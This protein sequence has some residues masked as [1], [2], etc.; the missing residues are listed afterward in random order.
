VCYAHAVSKK[1]A[2]TLDEGFDTSEF[3]NDFAAFMRLVAAIVAN[4]LSRLHR[5][6]WRVGDLLDFVEEHG[7]DL[8]PAAPGRELDLSTL[9][10]KL[11]AIFDAMLDERYAADISQRQK[12][13]ADRFFVLR[14]AL[15]EEGDISANENTPDQEGQGVCTHVPLWGLRRH[16]VYSLEECAKKMLRW[17][18]DTLPAATSDH[19]GPHPKAQRNELIRQRYASGESIPK[20]AIA[21]DLS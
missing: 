9:Q 6:G 15:Y 5:K 20:L 10:G 3:C 18:S 13:K 16:R 11:F 2:A 8:I 1:L 7:V 12:D 19:Y 14:A 17:L 21:F 4:D